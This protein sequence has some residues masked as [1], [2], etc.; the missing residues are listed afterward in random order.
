M[1]LAWLNLGRYYDDRHARGLIAGV[2]EEI[3][4]TRNGHWRWEPDAGDPRQYVARTPDGRIRRW[5]RSDGGKVSLGLQDAA[6]ENTYASQ[7]LTRGNATG[8][9]LDGQL[10]SLWEEVREAASRAAGS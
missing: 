1:R 10:G 2:E 8:A 3:R 5:V 7:L 6:T 9:E 4:L